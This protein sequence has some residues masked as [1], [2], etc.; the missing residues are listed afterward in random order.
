MV[1]T[2]DI[3]HPEEVPSRVI[4]TIEVDLDVERLSSTYNQLVVVVF[5]GVVIHFVAVPSLLEQ[6]NSRNI[7]VVY[8]QRKQSRETTE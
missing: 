7:K 1:L 8:T 4:G 2:N 3:F 5:V 6:V